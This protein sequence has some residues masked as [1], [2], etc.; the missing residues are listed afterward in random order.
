MLAFDANLKDVKRGKEFETVE[1]SEGARFLSDGEIRQNNG[2]V[3]A[4]YS[5]MTPHHEY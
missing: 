3:L 2:V 4:E 1:V 5:Q